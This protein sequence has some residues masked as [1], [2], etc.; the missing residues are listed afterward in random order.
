MAPH[1]ASHAPNS[2]PSG[3]PPFEAFYAAYLAAHRHPANRALHLLAKLAMLA[4]LLA[5]ALARQPLLLLAIPVVG[6]A[7]CW[8]GHLLFEGNHPTSWHDPAASLLGSLRLLARGGSGPA[9]R[10]G[11]PYYSLLAD[12]HMCAAMMGLQRIA[13]GPA[14]AHDEASDRT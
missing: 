8:L 1:F 3:A 4:L 5:S 6:I 9:P 7:P 12:L 13:G 10:S 2:A 11:R 14:A